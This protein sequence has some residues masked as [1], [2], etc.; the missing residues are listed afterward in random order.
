MPDTDDHKQTVREAFTEQAEASASDELMPDS[1]R[2]D[3]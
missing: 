2:I 1:E 3:A